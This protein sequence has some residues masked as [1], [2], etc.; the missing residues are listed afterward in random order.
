MKRISLYESLRIEPFEN[1]EEEI[2]WQ[3]QAMKM[4]KVIISS[5]LTQRQKQV[6]VLYFYR[7]MKQRQIAEKLGITESDVSHIKIN[8]LKKIKTY[9][10]LVRR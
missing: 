4:L 6:I 1:K 8:A 7:G 5:R 10:E 9:L 2:S 3:R